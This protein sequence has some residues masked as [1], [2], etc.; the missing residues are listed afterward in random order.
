[1]IDFVLDFPHHLSH[2]LFQFLLVWK[3]HS[4]NLD[5]FLDSHRYL[6]PL[7]LDIFSYRVL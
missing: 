6:C 3:V 7:S 2:N 5:L 1:M 4:Y